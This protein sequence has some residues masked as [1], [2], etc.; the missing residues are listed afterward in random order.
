VVLPN[1]AASGQVA[2]NSVE[3]GVVLVKSSGSPI[4]SVSIISQLAFE[5]KGCLHLA[6]SNTVERIFAEISQWLLLELRRRQQWT[7][8]MLYAMQACWI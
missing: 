5:L 7:A 4:G 3:T 8:A 1:L 2:R 6:C